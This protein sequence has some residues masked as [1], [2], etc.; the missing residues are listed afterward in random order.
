[1]ARF[2]FIIDQLASGGA[3]RSVIKLTRALLERQH[4][5]TLV[6]LRDP[7]TLPVPEGASVH[8]VPFT[9]KRFWQ[10]QQRYRLHAE[11]LDSY[12]DELGEAF[13]LVVANLNHAHQV[14]A[15]SKL[16][17]KAWLCIRSDPWQR[18]ISHKQGWRRAIKRHK[19]KALYRDKRILTLTQDNLRSLDRIGIEPARTEVIPNL[20]ELEHI[21]ERM[22]DALPEP[23]LEQRDFCLFVGRLNMRQKRL[24]RLL[25]GYKASGTEMPLVMVGDGD[26][27]AVEEV[28]KRAA[29]LGIEEQVML[30]GS[31]DNPY[32]YMRRA[33]LLL[34]ASDYEG[35]PN[36][37][38]EALAC[39]TP[40]VST[41]CLSGPRDILQGDLARGLVTPKEDI[42]KFG[43]AI[44]DLLG[45]P[46]IIRPEVLAQYSPGSV[47]D[48]YL[49]LIEEEK[50]A[51]R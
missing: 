33:R 26:T 34:L 6:S 11:R 25:E 8:V 19:V 1:M 3:P 16:S 39:G 41:D 40:V 17:S 28:K 7:V 36:V 50:A 24:D 10:K 35:L 4:Q 37:I 31:R 46:P 51:S 22:L 45:N 43:Q 23:E 27:G 30:L 42:K 13:D 12:L 5:V 20:V 32:P 9:P 14:L 38:I 29:A 2:L 49:E 47:A 18:L 48:R 15:R 44:S 21:Q